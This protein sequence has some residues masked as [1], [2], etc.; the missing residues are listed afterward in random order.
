[1]S[2]AKERN[3]LDMETLQK[4]PYRLDG[5]ARWCVHEGKDKERNSN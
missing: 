2:D 3:R 1:V 4:D 5:T